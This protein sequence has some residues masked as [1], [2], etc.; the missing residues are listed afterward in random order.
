MTTHKLHEIF[1]AVDDLIEA[2]DFRALN[3][4]LLYQDVTKLTPVEMLGLVRSTYRARRALPSW[5]DTV[6]RVRDELASRGE[7]FVEKLLVNL[8]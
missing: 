4:Y 1:N 5:Q 3:S 2:R 7:P 8:L 6:Y